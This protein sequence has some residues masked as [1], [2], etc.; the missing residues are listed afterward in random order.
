MAAMQQ[1]LLDQLFVFVLPRARAGHLHCLGFN[2]YDLCYQQRVPDKEGGRTVWLGLISKHLSEQAR[3]LSLVC[4]HLFIRDLQNLEA[5]TAG[6]TCLLHRHLAFP[7][8]G[9]L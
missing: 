2:T 8:H 1:H 3:K 5:L 7:W 4:L 9:T 6:S